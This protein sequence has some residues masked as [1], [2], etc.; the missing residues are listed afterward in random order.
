MSEETIPQ[1]CSLP[2]G[3]NRRPPL[4]PGT[5]RRSRKLPWSRRSLNGPSRISRQ[6]KRPGMA[7][8]WI[9]GVPRRSGAGVRRFPNGK[10]ARRGAHQGR[11]G[12]RVGEVRVAT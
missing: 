6:A 4:A 2:S 10:G 11:S 8:G 9:G 3:R 5:C 7:S 1:R 12:D